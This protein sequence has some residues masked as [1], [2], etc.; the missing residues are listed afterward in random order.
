MNVQE[1]V[2][3]LRSLMNEKQI[4]A[5]IVPSADNHQSEYVGEHFKARAFITGF[6]G[7]AGDAVIT[8][9]AAY[10]WTDARY[11][12]QAEKQLAGS[13]IK[14]FKMGESGVP[15]IQ[16]YLD[17]VLPDN[18]TLGF[19]GRVIAM[20]EGQELADAFAG[21]KVKI[22]YHYDLIDTIWTDRP[23]LSQEPAFSLAEKYTG[24][25]TASKLAR[26]RAEMA[27]DHATAH[28]I[29]TLDDICWLINMRGNDVAYSPL[30]LSYAIVRMDSMDLFIDERKLSDEAK[31]ALTENHIT[32]HPYNDIYEVVKTFGADDTIL[33]DPTKINYA[34]YN[35]IPDSVTKVEKPNPTILYKACKNQ[36][37]V[38]NTINAHVKDGVAVTKFMRWLKTHVGHETITEVSAAGKLD[39]FR[40]EGDGYLWQSFEPICAYKEHAAIVHYSATP[41]T[42]MELKPEHMFLC[43]T[44]GNYYEGSTDI[45]RTFILGDIS[46]TEKLHFTTVARSM[47]NL[48]RTRFLY[49]CKGYNLDILARLPMWEQ[50]I[51]YKH[52]TGHGVGYL[53]NVHEGPS[54]FRWQIVPSRNETHSLEAGMIITDEP[55][56]Y[57]EDSHGV[58]TENELVVRKGEANEF[59]QFMYLEPITYVPIDLDGIDEAELNRE[60]KAYLN[61][62]HKK[63]YDMIAPYLNDEEQEWLKSYT[64]EI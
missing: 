30:L 16:E 64:R 29:T 27:A 15:S 34:I 12:I 6:T 57:I 50:N 18:G 24:E 8:K 47:M 35:N 25:S 44:G 39:E 63:V 59:G 32:L 2:S 11:F 10:L 38:Q 60:E 40:K 37:E 51:D 31:A 48:A 55:G 7:S 56:I 17:T 4:D 5:Y 13:G 19:D 36:V 26:V 28:V 14:L 58:R 53:L 33:I 62:Y 21:K 41:E 42:D 61:S 9:D 54:G 43:D 20:Q 49:G 22:E 45:T 52:G 3:A 23:A 46:D 1:R